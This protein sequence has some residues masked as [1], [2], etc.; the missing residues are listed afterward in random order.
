MKLNYIQEVA[1]K[2]NISIIKGKTKTGKNKMKTKAQ[3]CEEINST[4]S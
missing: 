1:E 4:I 2:F 3:L